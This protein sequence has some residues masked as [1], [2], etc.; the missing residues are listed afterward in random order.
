[1]S[2]PWV[3]REARE[4]TLA[5]VRARL[6]AATFVAAWA[7]G[8]AMSLEQAVDYALEVASS[9]LEPAGHEMQ[10][11]KFPAGVAGIIRDPPATAS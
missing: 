4:F 11:P 3:A 5:T 10:L 7:Q 1:M 2:L 8:R 6:D 9:L